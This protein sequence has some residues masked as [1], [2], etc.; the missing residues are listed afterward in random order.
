M[1]VTDEGCQRNASY[2]YIMLE[3]RLWLYRGGQFVGGGNRSARR[4][5]PTCGK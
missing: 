5:P 4:K 3:R 2:A 1:K